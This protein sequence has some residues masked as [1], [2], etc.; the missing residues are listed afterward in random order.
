MKAARS[1]NKAQSF[2]F[3]GR[4]AT[5]LGFSPPENVLTYDASLY[6][7]NVYFGIIAVKMA[8]TTL[9]ILNLIG[10]FKRLY[11]FK[12]VFACDDLPKK[13]ILPA[14]V[15]VNLSKHDSHGSH[16]V[17]LFFDEKRTADYF[18]SFGF[19]PRQQ[20][21]ILFITTLK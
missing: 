15:V 17:G 13:F 4:L 10:P 19:P 1:E 6:V 9:D 2:H 3:Y 18:D 14:A 20:D 7:G 21:I 11:I 5:Q 16:C 8:L 12:D